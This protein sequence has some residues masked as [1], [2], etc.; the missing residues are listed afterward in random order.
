MNI[1]TFNDFHISSTVEPCDILIQYFC[2][3]LA[4]KQ[5]STILLTMNLHNAKSRLSI[6]PQRANIRLREARMV[7]SSAVYFKCILKFI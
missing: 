7:N 2:L 6:V 3:M 1:I 5:S 4:W